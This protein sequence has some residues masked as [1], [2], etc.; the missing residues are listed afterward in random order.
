MEVVLQYMRGDER[1]DPNQWR[2]LAGKEFLNPW[3]AN[4]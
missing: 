2:V 1:N 3:Y 4:C